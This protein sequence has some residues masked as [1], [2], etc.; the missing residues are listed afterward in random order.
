MRKLNIPPHGAL[1][2]YDSCVTAIGSVVLQAPYL[3]DRERIEEAIA[4]FDAASQMAGWTNL[5]RAQWGNPDAVIVGALT[6][7]QLTELYNGPFRR[8]VEVRL[9]DEGVLARHNAAE[10]ITVFCLA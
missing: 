8:I 10:P 6:K 2:T 1:A 5:P 4:S 9:K 3:A 7:K